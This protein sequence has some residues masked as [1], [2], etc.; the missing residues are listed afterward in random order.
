MEREQGFAAVNGTRLYYEV[1]GDG[2]PVA[3]VHGFTLD[4]RMW[5]DQFAPLAAHYRVVRYDA[6]GFGRSDPP[7][8][9][10]YA[11]HD[12]L[13]ALLDQL[14]LDRA[15]II[16][17]SMGGGIAADFAVAYPERTDTL[18][19]IDAALGGHR[20][21]GG[22]GA[23]VKPIGD[24]AREGG[25]A[26]A[27]GRWLAHG[28]FAP[29]NENP[30]VAARLAAMVGDYSGWH[31]LNRDPGRGIEPPLLARP[32]DLA[33]PTLAIVGER[34]LP[35]FQ[36]MARALVA[37]APQARLAVVPGAGHMANMEEPAAVNRLILD[38]LRDATRDVL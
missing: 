4:T 32:G 26:V 24:G 10:P 29:A 15:A 38:F 34:D 25:I 7:G 13:R 18:V 28:L 12:D 5:D 14:G 22:W 35:D 1:A 33:A 37:G 16:G 23:T 31:W 2:P 11:H 19:L 27:K 3:L 9:E 21:S 17:L 20:W 8:G 6:R 36:A 30:A